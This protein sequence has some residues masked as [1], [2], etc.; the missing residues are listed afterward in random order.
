MIHLKQLR[1]TEDTKPLT[2]HIT[3]KSKL[4]TQ[5]TSCNSMHNTTMIFCSEQVCFTKNQEM[6][7]GLEETLSQ[8]FQHIFY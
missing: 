6:V 4:D 2:I 1:G 5:Y 8:Q 3:Q 7:A